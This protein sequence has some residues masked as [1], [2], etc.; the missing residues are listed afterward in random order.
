MQNE[1]PKQQ[2]KNTITDLRN[3][4]FD[5]LESLVDRDDPMDTGR[6]KTICE[7]SKQIIETAKV[8]ITY[9]KTAGGTDISPFIEDGRH[10]QGEKRIVRPKKPPLELAR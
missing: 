9:I 6:A 8:E 4:L 3:I 7:V 2:T 1:P 10:R 5:T